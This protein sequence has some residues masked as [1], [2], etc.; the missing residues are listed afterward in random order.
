MSYADASE[1]ADEAGTI[2]GSCTRNGRIAV[3]DSEGLPAYARSTL[4]YTA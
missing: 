3:R 1:K 4:M 2:R